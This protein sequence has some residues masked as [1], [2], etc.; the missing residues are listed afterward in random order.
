MKILGLVIVAVLVAFLT[1]WVQNT[2]PDAVVYGLIGMLVI[3]YISGVMMGWYAKADW[4]KKETDE[5]T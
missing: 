3:G 4:P 1:T 2:G 5:E